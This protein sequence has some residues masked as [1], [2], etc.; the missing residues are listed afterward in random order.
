MKGRKI[1]RA[2]IPPPWGEGGREAAGWG[3]V[4]S[5]ERA[6]AL[7]KRLTPQEARLW[8]RLRELRRVGFHVRRQAPFRGYILDFV[9]YARRIVI[10]VDGG[11]HAADE[12]A[13]R[14]TVRDDVLRREGFQVLRFWN[15]EVN[16][17]L[18]GVMETIQRAL[19]TV[20]PTRPPPGATLPTRGRED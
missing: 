3:E 7:R 13:A 18:D 9:C 12:A 17:N 5:V 4:V 14:D 6:R 11:Q 15:T 19:A 2:D 10:E 16:D 8:T 1:D 20:P